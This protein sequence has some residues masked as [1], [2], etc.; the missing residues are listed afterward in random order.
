M[1][2]GAGGNVAASDVNSILNRPRFQCN[3]SGTIAHNSVTAL[4]PSVANV[5]VGTMWTSGSTI[6]VPTAGEYEIGIV[7]RYASQ[8]STTGHRQARVHINGSEY[9]SF[10]NPGGAGVNNTNTVVSGVIRIVLAAGDDVQFNAYQTGGVSLALTGNNRGW[11][12]RIIQ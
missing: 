7:L 2:V 12:E 10:Q 5:N 6:T 9:M 1:T 3:F 11:V 8:A 4:T